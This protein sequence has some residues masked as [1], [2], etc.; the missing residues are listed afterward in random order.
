[1][2]TIRKATVL[3]FAAHAY[4]MG[5]NHMGGKLSQDE[6]G[7]W[8]LDKQPLETFLAQHEGEEVILILGSLEDN[9]PIPARTCRTCGRDYQDAECPYCRAN[10]IR[11]RG[12]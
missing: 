9:R 1:M 12:R 4:E 5:L 10:R 6:H 8:F 3:K 7:R 2:D 11:L